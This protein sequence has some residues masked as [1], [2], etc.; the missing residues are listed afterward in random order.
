MLALGLY[1]E[2]IYGLEFLLSYNKFQDQMLRQI[3]PTETPG[4]SCFLLMSD[5]LTN[6]RSYIHVCSAVPTVSTSAPLLAKLC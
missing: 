1:H 4:V 3:L 6:F 5:Y 2:Y